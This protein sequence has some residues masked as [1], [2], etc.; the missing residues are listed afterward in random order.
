MKST[1]FILLAFFV[2]F[3]AADTLGNC[4]FNTSQY[5]KELTNI[6]EIQGIEVKVDAY[7]K[8]TQNTLEAFIQ[9]E[10]SITPK[11]KKRFLATVLVQYSFGKWCKSSRQ[12]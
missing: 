2:Q 8:W 10:P 7:R 5:L 11:Y 12:K 9:R 6:N 4:D 1:L 3:A